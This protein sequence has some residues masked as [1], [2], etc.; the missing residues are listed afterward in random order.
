[1]QQTRISDM[2]DTAITRRFG[3]RTPILNAGMAVV[4]RP[5]L[6]AAV[7]NA[8]GLGMIGADVAPPEALRAM[9]RAVKAK[10][11][12]PFGVDMLAP[13]ITDAHLDALAEEGVALCV[14]FWGAPTRDQ[15]ARIRAGGAAFWMQVGSVEEALD[16]KALG[17][18]AIIVQGLEGGGHNRSVA[19][20][21]TLLP[22]VRAAV[23][24]VPVIAAGG[25]AD[26]AG[27]AAALALGAEAVWC[28]TRFLASVEADA[29]DGYKARVLAAGVG[30]TL[31]TTL[32]GPEMP[33]Q[34]MRVI[35][36]SATD[37][38]AGREEEAMAATAGQT[39][40]TLRTP[41]GPV[42]LPRFSVY[43]PTRD[44]DGDLD[45]LCLTAGQSAGGI[46][47]LKPAARIVDEMTREAIE[48][49]ADLARRA[50]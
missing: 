10:T 36:N 46:R 37:E 30:D 8:G 50:G 34:P 15:V 47:D 13:M 1:M 23:V 39:V 49:I 12:R 16:A 42:P 31:S 18:E 9:I 6:A 44:V 35:R 5:D 43:L 3:L 26:G 40:A 33:L 22:A 7:S 38:W 41:D 11:D 2:I 48:V 14:V 25:V 19:T 4:A 32:F 45:Q 28:G 17:A 24:P 20:T 29:H 21:F 27:M